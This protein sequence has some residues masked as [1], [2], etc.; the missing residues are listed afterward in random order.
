M[1]A[2]AR[3]GGGRLYFC[4]QFDILTIM[5]KSKSIAALAALAH[6]V[7]LDVFRLLVQRGPEGMSAGDIGHALDIAA[8]T[9]S[10]HLTTLLHA[11]LVQKSRSGRQVIYS[12]RF[13]SINDLMGFLMDN[14]CQG[15]PQACAFLEDTSMTDS[16]RDGAC[17]HG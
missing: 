7:R 13:E 8:A 11:D 2:T 15:N 12:A 9:L 5:E 1:A 16:K 4:V 10:F 6:D 14:C 17:G 3:T